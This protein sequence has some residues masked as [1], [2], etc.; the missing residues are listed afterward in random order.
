MK[1]KNRMPNTYTG[2][3]NLHIKKG[4]QNESQ[5]IRKDYKK[6]ATQRIA[7]FCFGWMWAST[8]VVW[9]S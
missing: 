5:H 8:L 3:M 4:S 6:L 2:P 7:K 9:S 1:H